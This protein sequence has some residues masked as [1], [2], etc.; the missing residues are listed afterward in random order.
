MKFSKIKLVA[1]LCIIF[2]FTLS[3][4][5]ADH[6]SN[7][8]F[9][10]EWDSSFNGTPEEFTRIHNSFKIQNPNLSGLNDNVIAKKSEKDVEEVFKKAAAAKT[11]YENTRNSKEKFVAQKILNNWNALY[12][13][14]RILVKP[15]INNSNQSKSSPDEDFRVYDNNIKP[16]RNFKVTKSEMT[17]EGFIIEFEY[18]YDIIQFYSSIKG[19]E[20]DI[21]FHRQW[22]F[23]AIHPEFL[24]N[25]KAE[26]F[27]GGSIRPDKSGARIKKST[28]NIDKYYLKTHRQIT[29][30]YIN[31]YAIEYAHKAN[32]NWP[33]NVSEK[34]TVN[35]YTEKWRWKPIVKT[36]FDNK[37]LIK[38]CDIF[39]KT[40]HEELISLRTGSDIKGA[41]AENKTIF[42]SNKIIWSTFG[43]LSGLALIGFIK[44]KFPNISKK[45]ITEDTK[46]KADIEDSEE[47]T[48]D[49][50]SI[51]FNTSGCSLVV[52]DG[53]AE[54][55]KFTA[56]VV[57]SNKIGWKII[58]E[59]AANSSFLSVNALS[60]ITPDKA[61]FGVNTVGA[62]LNDNEYVKDCLLNV[63][64]VLGEEKICAAH[65][66]VVAREGLFV[67]SQ[68]PL[69][70]IADASEIAELK[71]TAT[72][73]QKI[74][75]ETDQ[76]A[77]TNIKFTLEPEDDTAKKAFETAIVDFNASSEWQDTRKAIDSYQ[78]N[79][80]FASR[81]F[82]I[83][84]KN[85]L[86]SGKNS[87]GS[88]KLYVG[89][90]TIESSR[91]YSINLRVEMC[92]PQ[93]PT[94]SERL[95]QEYK[96]C[97][98]IIEK[99]VPAES[100]YQ[101]KFYEMVDRYGPLFGPD[102]LFKLR[103]DIWAIAQ[104][105]WEAKGLQGYCEM[106]ERLETYDKL[107]SWT[108]WTGDMALSVLLNLK[109]GGG[110]GGALSQ[111]GIM[112]VKQMTVSAINHFKDT[113]EIKG[114]FDADDCESWLNNQL[115]MQLFSTP[116]YMLTAASLK[117]FITPGRA[118]SLMFANVFLRALIM[119]FD[120]AKL[121]S[122][123]DE[124]GFDKDSCNDICK[125]A[126][127]ASK[128]CFKALSSMLLTG[129]LT[130]AAVRSAIKNN[131]KVHDDV[132]KQYAPEA[133]KQAEIPVKK[134]EIYD[135]ANTTDTVNTMVA[136]IK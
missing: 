16:F 10:F 62:V 67:I 135:P 85:A 113:I 80:V 89:N 119:N 111:T 93:E 27:V 115:K 52:K 14:Y 66:A 42:D 35:T 101:E 91:G 75:V 131:T 8:K 38:I 84:T 22:V 95:E 97:R 108:E 82:K 78:N 12:R 56:K 136:N 72:R 74:Y 46:K 129:W 79:N 103:H 36:N 63:S 120:W 49:H 2:A 4:L 3:N 110:L 24:S 73:F 83:C 76:E 133:L 41:K 125:A 102:G 51:I 54:I 20:S 1:L 59:P 68:K 50:P 21:L 5:K 88:L 65:K 124:S 32:I 29:N 57:N 17:N 77:L 106:A 61:E 70:I 60:Q 127:I 96:N 134:A 86:P 47:K 31:S 34:F 81:V 121:G 39:G 58:A 90:L 25:G 23:G 19:K 92:A 53:G 104:K 64:A 99:F 30:T 122:K 132:L 109:T 123:W 11:Q 7:T 114:S 43:V 98:L 130:G 33:P 40:L 128:E 6:F 107:R 87:D 15:P 71:L 37:Y 48:Q 13:V 118:A 28:I 69:K 55:T 9:F 26:G 105:L 126:W 18:T 112:L 44:Q 117:G 100:G 116:D 94:R 45:S